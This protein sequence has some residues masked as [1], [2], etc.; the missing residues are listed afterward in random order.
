MP[1]IRTIPA[2]GPRATFPFNQRLG[3]S[4]TDYLD[5]GGTSTSATDGDGPRLKRSGWVTGISVQ[6]NVS[7]ATSGVLEVAAVIAGSVSSVAVASIDSSE[8]T[9]LQGAHA[10][11]RRGLIPFT[12]GNSLAARMNPTGTMAW[13]DSFVDIEVEYAMETQ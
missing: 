7:T 5:Y 1:G 3:R 11:F 4:A 9:G 8:G 13:D 12:E 10:T 2:V 6:T